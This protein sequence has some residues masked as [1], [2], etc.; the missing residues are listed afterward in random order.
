MAERLG[1]LGLLAL[2]IV[3]ALAMIPIESSLKVE[4]ER[5]KLADDRTETEFLT[6]AGRLKPEIAMEPT[7]VVENT[8]PEPSNFPDPINYVLWINISGFRGDYVEKSNAPFFGNLLLA[9]HSTS[10]TSP[11]FPSQNWPSLTS[12][13]TGRQPA[14]HGIIAETMKH[15]DSGEIVKRP[16]DLSLLQAEPIW[17]T[18]KRQGIR[19][20]VHDWPFSQTQPDEHAADVFLPEF[21]PD[22]TDEDR[23]KQL[24]DAWTSDTGEEKIRLAM[25]SLH[26]LNKIGETH[27][28]RAG[29]TYTAF[30]EFDRR[31]AEFFKQLEEAWPKLNRGADVLWVFI[32]TD[33][34]MAEVETLVNL[35]DFIS[36]AI[37][38]RIEIAVDDTVANIWLN[39]P[40]GTN[41][42]QF[43]D[44]MDE[45]LGRPIFWKMYVHDQPDEDWK[46][47]PDGGLTGERML[48]LQ[49]KYRF[50]DKKGSEATFPA[51]EVGGPLSTGGYA[52]DQTSVMRGQTFIFKFPE[53]G[54]EPVDMKNI[55]S[56]QIYP[57]VCEVLGIEPA[58][59]ADAAPL[60]LGLEAMAGD[61]EE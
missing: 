59:G 54:G 23:L 46:F 1:S 27:G 61:A 14:G 13:A 22:A 53:R 40:E 33:H 50:T 37:R 11:T 57:T 38:E 25:A 32:T 47:P 48:V 8:E 34:G 44:A 41:Q 35:E 26:D 12:M 20:L 30:T 24:L 17:T 49:P 10:R 43:I 18:A 6:L 39:L 52:V 31:M 42:A 55:Y 29:E 5:N 21:D 7:E 9:S 60:D 4:W 51:T 56:V 19:V 58:E 2:V 28:A 16:T 15:P 3:A 45:E 36:P